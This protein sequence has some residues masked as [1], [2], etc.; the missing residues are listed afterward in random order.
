M[1]E[2]DDFLNSLD[3]NSPEN[4]AQA[5][6]PISQE[7][8]RPQAQALSEEDFNNILSDMGFEEATEEEHD[9]SDDNTSWDDE[10]EE[11]YYDTTTYY[12]YVSFWKCN[13]FKIMTED[14]LKDYIG[15]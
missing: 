15:K 6:E 7:P 3:V 11:Y 5:E 14:E 4:T 8:E 13:G 12:V 2:F 1:S 9:G 10:D